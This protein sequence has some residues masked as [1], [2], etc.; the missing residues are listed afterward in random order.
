[1]ILARPPPQSPGD[2]LKTRADALEFLSRVIGGRATALP[3]KDAIREAAR[4]TH[5]DL[6]GGAGDDF[7]RVMKC[8]KLLSE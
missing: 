3:P 7:K 4:A 2:E 6:H 5:P 8:E 1:M